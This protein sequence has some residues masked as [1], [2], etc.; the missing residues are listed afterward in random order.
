M[1]LRLNYWTMRWVIAAW[2]TLS[3]ILNLIDRQSLS[4]LAPFLRDR[5]HLSV[6]D[7]AHVVTAFLVSYT[8]MYAVGG[9]L[10]DWIG[11]R[12]GMAAC[13]LWWSVC[14]M[15]TALVQGRL[16]LGL[17]RFLLGL[18]EPANYPAALRATTV[19]FPKSDRGLPIALFSSGSAVGN[20]LAPPLIAA[21]TLALGWRAAFVLP[22]LLGL[23]WVAGWL[24]I[25]HGPEAFAGAPMESLRPLKDESHNKSLFA[26]WFG[27]LKQRNVLALVVSRFISDPVWYFYVFWIPE[28]LKRE[29][30]FSLTDIG[31]YAWIPFVAGAV[32]GMTAG[33]TSDILVAHGMSPVRARTRI[34]YIAAA[35][36]PVGMWTSKV[37]SAAFAIFLIAVMAFVVYCWFINTAA[38]I[39]DVVPENVVGSVLGFMGT[40]GSAA[41]ALFSLFLGYLLT[42]YSYG[43]AFVLAGTMH[44]LAALVLRS[45][46]TEMSPALQNL[47][48]PLPSPDGGRFG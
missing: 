10:V 39:P 38:I 40:A 21:I 2:L 30:G 9:R 23:I 37:H 43:P 48:A 25:Y 6:Q 33:W 34:L 35:L 16:S 12:V 3:T 44:L 15:L 19:W 42:R 32:G 14:T 18:G 36:A 7:Y 29:R 31:L 27:L 13:I 22:G 45:L 20:V 17:V 47:H 28:Y 26:S 24:I 11:E 8:V 46:M 41:G 4:V 1:M 5:L